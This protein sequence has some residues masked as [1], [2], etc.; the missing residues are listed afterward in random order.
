MG[1]MVE[2]A[3]FHVIPW[4]FCIFLIFT[5]CPIQTVQK[6]VLCSTFSTKNWPKTC[7][8]PPKPEIYDLFPVDTVVVRDKIR[9][10]QSSNILRPDPWRHRRPR[11]QQHWVSFDIIH[12]SIER[13]L[14]YVSRS[15]CP[16]DME[17]GGGKNTPPPCQS[18]YGNT[19]QAR[20][21]VRCI[22]NGSFHANPTIDVHRNDSNFEDIEFFGVLRWPN[23]EYRVETAIK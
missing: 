14:N 9:H 19:R 6:V 2:I 7:I 20:V 1:L 17:R 16:W 12:R 3:T 13:H 22:T 23:L 10:D 8:T 21:N 5:F 15:S 4:D 11:S 18:C